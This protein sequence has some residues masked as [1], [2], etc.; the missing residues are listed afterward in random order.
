MNRIRDIKG[1]NY[2]PMAKRS[3]DVTL[4]WLPVNGA[5]AT[6]LPTTGS[7]GVFSGSL[8]RSELDAIKLAGFNSIRVLGSFMSYYINQ[9]GWRQVL[10]ILV[11]ELRARRMGLTFQVW[12]GIPSGSA[13]LAIDVGGG[14]FLRGA[15]FLVEISSYLPSTLLSTHWSLA[16]AF[17]ASQ[18]AITPANERWVSFWP[19]PFA[20]VEWDTQGAYASWADTKFKAAVTNYLTDLGAFFSRGAA[21]EVLDS[22]DLYNEPNVFFADA[23]RKTNVSSFIKT[24]HDLIRAQ[25]SNPI[26]C[27][28]GWAGSGSGLNRPLIAAGV[29]LTY[30]SFHTYAR[31]TLSTA[32]SE[33]VAEAGELPTLITEFY[34]TRIDSGLIAGYLDVLDAAGIKGYMWCY[35]MNGHWPALDGVVRGDGTAAT[36]LQNQSLTHSTVNSADD[37]RIRR[38]TGVAS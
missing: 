4:A 7:D 12:S 32:I 16:D 5:P 31:S 33:A 11:T 25:F 17:T 24:T 8:L 13:A 21:L 9:A 23:T 34:D 14:P 28:V 20:S 6:G 27:T 19:E 2:L 15:Q 26:N 36:L 37:N 3:Q 1:C 38:W 29:P 22:F 18:S 35:L 30:M 10:D